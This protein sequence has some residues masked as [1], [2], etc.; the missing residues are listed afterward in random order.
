MVDHR[1]TSLQRMTEP[2]LAPGTGRITTRD[3]YVARVKDAT[4]KNLKAGYITKT[5]ADATI[6]DAEKLRFGK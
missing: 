1:M 2:L 4:E 6:R 3:A 5:D